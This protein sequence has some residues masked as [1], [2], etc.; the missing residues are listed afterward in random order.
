MIFQKILKNLLRVK[1]C[2]IILT[3]VKDSFNFNYKNSKFS[4]INNDK[5]KKMK[6]I[7]KIKVIYSNFLKFGY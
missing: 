6:K 1:F 3:D 5:N 4:F 2:N 7:I